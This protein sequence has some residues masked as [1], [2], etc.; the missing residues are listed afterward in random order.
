MGFVYLGSQINNLKIINNDNYY[1]FGDI[2]VFFWNH[3]NLILQFI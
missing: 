3:L 1:L 2:F